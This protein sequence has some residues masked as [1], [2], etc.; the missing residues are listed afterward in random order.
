MTDDD[1]ENPYFSEFRKEQEFIEKKQEEEGSQSDEPSEKIK[2]PTDAP[3]YFLGHR[4][5]FLSEQEER[6]LFEKY[7]GSYND[8]ITSH[9]PL[10]RKYARSYSIFCINLG[11]M[12]YDSDIIEDYFSLGFFGL[13]KAIRRYDI[14]KRARLSTFA[15]NYIQSE[16]INSPRWDRVSHSNYHLRKVRAAASCIELLDSCIV[17]LE[18]VPLLEDEIA[19]K[20]KE[21]SRYLDTK[22]KNNVRS[23]FKNKENLLE[24]FEKALN[25]TN[26][27]KKIEILIETFSKV[28]DLFIWYC[29]RLTFEYFNSS[30]DELIPSINTGIIITPTN[31]PLVNEDLPLA[32]D[33][34]L[35]IFRAEKNPEKKLIFYFDVFWNELLDTKLAGTP[36]ILPKDVQSITEGIKIPKQYYY[37]EELNDTELS[38]LLNIS[39]G[40]VNRYRKKIKAEIS[41]ALDAM[42][43]I[44]KHLKAD[45]KNEKEEEMNT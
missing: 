34:I 39:Y 2:I 19:L 17:F 22:Y 23:I 11:K 27:K 21:I 8:L 31:A 15:R 40:K 28:K 12:G 45:D 35:K 43:G 13:I 42:F 4:I 41:T 3:Y 25:S 1:R 32:Y 44:L 10:V 33:I 18:D 29:N 30:G 6:G 37:K 14:S 7:Q 38:K 26:I 36:E 24:N 16:I 20:C 9:I 5:K